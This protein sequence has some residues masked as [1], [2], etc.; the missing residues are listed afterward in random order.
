MGICIILIGAFS[1]VS[2]KI[3]MYFWTADRFGGIFQYANTCALFLLIGL[4]LCYYQWRENRVL[5][6]SEDWWKRMAKSGIL[7]M[8]LLMTGSRSVL[9]L[10][11]AWGILHSFRNRRFRKLFLGGVL[12]VG[13]LSGGLYKYM[14]AG[15]QNVSRIFTILSS[16]STLYGRLLYNIDG[17]AILARYPMGL[18]YLGYYYVQQAM[19]TGVY[20]IRYIHNDI[21]QIG[22]DYGVFSLALF[23]VYMVWQ[24][25]GGKQ[26]VWKKELMITILAASLTDFHMQYITIAFIMVLCLDLG[27]RVVVQRPVGRMT[28]RSVSVFLSLFFLYLCIPCFAGHLGKY[29]TVLQFLPGDT[30]SLRLAMAD[31]ADMETAADWAD[32][33]LEH[34]VY[35]AEAY[36]V[37][38]YMAAMQGD[39]AQM[40]RNEDE[41]LRLEKYNVDRYRAYDRLLEHLKVEC[42]ESGEAESAKQ[43]ERKQAEIREQLEALRGETSALAYKLRDI[44]VFTW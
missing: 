25:A 6:W 17:A 24:F 13:V 4:E 27:E 36:N 3:K 7:L 35:I 41:V 16:N 42:F 39:I 43:I 38:A 44:P 19:Q 12:S 8:G 10:G 14:G 1:L 18:G 2:E 9:L 31:A 28:A 29:Q 40:M 30:V 23:A 34:N 26:P 37:K 22:L 21:L 5:K 33:I 20:T 32:R 11:L 15:A